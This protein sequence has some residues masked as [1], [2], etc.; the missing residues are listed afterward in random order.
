MVFPVTMDD[1]GVGGCVGSS[2][3]QSACV[4]DT[5]ARS[6]SCFVGMTSSLGQRLK[7]SEDGYM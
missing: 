2:C 6:R 7:K 1:G 4:G 3:D 5:T